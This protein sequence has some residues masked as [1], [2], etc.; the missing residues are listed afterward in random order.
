MLIWG[1]IGQSFCMA[2]LTGV[3]WGSA[4]T[5]N[6][7]TPIVAA[8]FLFGFNTCFAFAYLGGSWLLQAELPPISVRAPSNALSTAGNWSFNFMVVMITPVA[9]ENIDCYTYTIFAVI[10]ILMVPALYF[11][12][13]E[14]A[15]RTLEELDDIFGQCDPW[16]PWEVVG[17][18]KRHPRLSHPS[19]TASALAKARSLNEQGLLKPAPIGEH[20]EKM[21]SIQS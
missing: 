8:V 15:G 9:F 19:Q 20:I 17:I 4:H 7:A 11:L 1:A 14:T 16:K 6:K 21:S 10:N 5:D 18:A 13:P 12:Y 2:I 3:T